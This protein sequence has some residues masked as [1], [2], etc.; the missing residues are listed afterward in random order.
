MKKRITKTEVKLRKKIAS[1]NNRLYYLARTGKISKEEVKA[2]RLSTKG[3]RDM[4]V[5]EMR[6]KIKQIKKY[7]PVKR[8]IDERQKDID[9]ALK[10]LDIQLEDLS[11]K[12][13]TTANK[14]KIK[15]IERM[16]N[17]F[18]DLSARMIKSGYKL[19]QNDYMRYYS[20]KA[21][22]LLGGEEGRKSM[23]SILA[24]F[25]KSAS[26][27]NN[28][29][30]RK[31]DIIERLGKM[32]PQDFIDMYYEEKSIRDLLNKYKAYVESLSSEVSGDEYSDALSGFI[33]STDNMFDILETILEERGM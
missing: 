25:E 12:R 8:I 20:A 5:S 17:E 2:S 31:Y 11:R 14:Y 27:S 32:K 24:V 6:S 1:I 21:T 19:N 7:E 15:N 29:L 16:I 9:K 18:T 30:D 13:R 28:D 10:Y 33:E 23:N 4:V 22:S 3:I 26:I